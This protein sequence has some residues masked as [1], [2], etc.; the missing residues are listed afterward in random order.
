MSIV[1]TLERPLGYKIQISYDEIQIN[2]REEFDNFGTFVLSHK[3]YSVANE[4]DIKI[5]DYKSW[6]KVKKAILKQ[7]GPCIVLPVYMYDH[8]GVAL[9]T[10][11]TGCFTDTWDSGVLGL[12]FVSH[13][14]IREEYSI[15][16]VTK[17]ALSKSQDRLV[18]EVEIYGAYLNG[19][20]FDYAILN[21]AGQIIEGSVC[22][23]F[24]GS[25]FTK[26][27][28]IE[29]AEE[30]IE[31]HKEQDTQGFNKEPDAVQLEL[32]LTV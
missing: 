3:R 30:F 26:N 31:W 22:G 17:E 28:L 19:E 4:S 21:T 12:I 14:R 8:S 16:R 13:K 1:E 15:K 24:Y 18:N 5:S 32:E 29:A 25:N 20:V 9:S 23:G 7:N 11:R 6:Y 2:P 27:G 10:V